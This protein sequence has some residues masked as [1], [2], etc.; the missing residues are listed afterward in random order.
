VNSAAPWTAERRVQELCCNAQIFARLSVSKSESQVTDQQQCFGALRAASFAVG[1]DTETCSNGHVQRDRPLGMWVYKFV[2]M[3]C[4]DCLPGSCSNQRSSMISKQRANG[5][6]YST[7]GKLNAR[8]AVIPAICASPRLFRYS[9][10][11]TTWSHALRYS[12]MLL[13]FPCLLLSISWPIFLSLIV[14]EQHDTHL[15]LQQ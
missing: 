8:S 13:R 5:K 2:F 10:T 12:I 4:W 7:Q 6:G 1:L 3:A 14:H 15:L 11:T 9:V